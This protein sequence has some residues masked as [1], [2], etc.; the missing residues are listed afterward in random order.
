MTVY[1]LRKCSKKQEST[2]CKSFTHRP[3]RGVQT[4]VWRVQTARRRHCSGAPCDRQNA[5]CC[6]ICAAEP[7]RL[8]CVV[9][10][11][12]PPGGSTNQLH[13]LHHLPETYKLHHYIT[14]PRFCLIV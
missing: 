3:F 14:T 10:G 11:L 13:Y 4:S 2:R 9:H 12:A 7:H 6:C 5:V 8:V 1:R